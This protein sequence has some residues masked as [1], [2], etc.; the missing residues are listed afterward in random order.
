MALHPNFHG[1]RVRRCLAFLWSNDRIQ[2]PLIRARGVRLTAGND[3]ILIDGLKNLEP[4][5]PGEIGI[6]T[7]NF[8][9]ARQAATK[10]LDGD[11]SAYLG[12]LQDQIVGFFSFYAQWLWD[13]D[14][15]IQQHL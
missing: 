10:Y 3:D 1:L 12:T 15:V 8:Y 9:A 13:I 5:L 6:R 11:V 7:S 14:G 4:D 2:K